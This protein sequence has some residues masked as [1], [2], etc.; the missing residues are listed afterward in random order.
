MHMY[1]SCFGYPHHPYSFRNMYVK[2][3]YRQ[4]VRNVSIHIRELVDFFFF[5]VGMTQMLP[6]TI[7]LKASEHLNDFLF[8]LKLHK[9]IHV[10]VHIILCV[11]L[12]L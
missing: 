10:H 4:T 2:R 1:I 12:Y 6:N 7:N 5:F 3:V 9:Y 11:Y 8:S